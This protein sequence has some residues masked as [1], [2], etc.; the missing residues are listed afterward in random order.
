MLLIALPGPSPASRWLIIVAVAHAPPRRGASG[1]RGGVAI[2]KGKPTASDDAV[3]V[4]PVV[5]VA[6]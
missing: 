2:A 4:I 1:A 5:A 6:L 3:F